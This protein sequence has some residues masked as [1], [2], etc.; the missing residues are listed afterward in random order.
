MSITFNAD[1]IF[2]MAEEIERNGV[3]FY[4]QAAKNVHDPKTKQMLLDMA[5][6]EGDHLT[7]FQEMR[8]SLSGQEIA[9]N[10]FDPDNE[11]ALY[12]QSMADGH[13]W[14]GKMTATQPLTGDESIEDILQ[15]AITAEKNSVVFYIGLK[16][17][18]SARAGKDKVDAIIQE[19]VGHIAILNRQL[20][21]MK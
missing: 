10:I 16:E 20:A 14:E 8:K 17:L 5:E 2:E 18:V 21:K 6:M 7:I 13:G 1:E 3:K 11:S 9:K 19:E 12:L 4:N 15:S